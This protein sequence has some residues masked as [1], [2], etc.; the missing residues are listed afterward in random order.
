MFEV[1]TLAQIV[2][3]NFRH[4]KAMAAKVPRELEESDIF[5]AHV[6]QDANGAM[7]LVRKPNNAAPRPSKL[8]L[9][10]LYPRH[11]RVEMLLE[12]PLQ[13]VHRRFSV[14]GHKDTIGSSFEMRH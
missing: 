10:R 1:G 12:E 6:V 8:A 4:G 2:G 11:R 14:R 5:F 9:Q 7:I 3:V 13:N